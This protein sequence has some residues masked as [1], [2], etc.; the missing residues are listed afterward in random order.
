MEN[1]L[2]SKRI[3]GTERTDLADKESYVNVMFDKTGRV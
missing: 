1:G 2:P 3:S